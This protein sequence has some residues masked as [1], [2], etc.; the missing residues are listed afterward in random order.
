MSASRATGS[1][2]FKEGTS[3]LATVPLNGSFQSVY[4]TAALS[5]GTHTITAAYGGDTNFS[6]SSSSGLAEVI[7]IVKLYLPRLAK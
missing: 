5:L 3:I 1:V 6:P 2:Q 7:T 4:S